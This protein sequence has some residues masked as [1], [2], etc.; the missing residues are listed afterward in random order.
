MEFKALLVQI[1]QNAKVLEEERR[2]FAE[3]A[4]LELSQV[5]TFNV[6]DHQSFDFH[7]LGP[8]QCL[9]IG[10]ASEASVLEPNKYPFVP[11]L[12]K[13]VLSCVEK[14]FPVF[15]SCFGFQAAVTALGGVIERNEEDFE[16]GTYPM[17]LTSAAKGDPLFYNLPADFM[18]VSVHQEKCTQ[19]PQN[20][21]LLAFT[22]ACPHAFRVANKP[23]W[24]FQFHPE[25]SKQNLVTRLAEYQA[26]YTE[27]QDHYQDV[28]DTL[29]ETPDA[30]KLLKNFISYTK[31]LIN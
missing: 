19:M 6:F 1:R 12:E 16:M 27:D 18:A 14:D 26:Q 23:F 17:Q 3:S 2:S 4:G 11:S 8:Y 22:E 7:L 30:A 24:G 9:F 10:G 5:H 13:L 31:S 25:L 15:A 29:Q 21:E 28:I 20:C